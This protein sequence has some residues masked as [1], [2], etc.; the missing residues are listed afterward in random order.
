MDLATAA[1]LKI[2]DTPPDEGFVKVYA[3][4]PTGV[5]FTSAEV[6]ATATGSMLFKCKAWNF[7]LQECQGDWVKIADITPGEDYIFILTPDDPGLAESSGTFFEG[8]ESNSLVTNNWSTS[9]AGD[10]WII[11]PTATSPGAYGGS[12]YYGFVEVN[13]GESILTTNV[14][15]AGYGTIVFSFYAGTAALDIGEYLA[16]DWYNGTDWIQLM[17]VED[18][19]TYTFYSYSL[20]NVADD[21]A[22]LAIRFRCSSAQNSEECYLDNI[23]VTGTEL[24]AII[25]LEDSYGLNSSLGRVDS[26]NTTNLEEIEYMELNFSIIAYGGD[27]DSW[28][29]NYT[30]AGFSSCAPGNKQSSQCYN[31]TNADPYKWIQFI[32][33]TNTTTYDGTQG[34]QGDRII[35]TQTGS[36][37]NINISIRIDEHYNPNV[38]KWYAALYNFSDVKWQDGTS[39]RITKNNMLK[40]EVNQDLIPL[41]ADQYKLDFRVNYSSTAPSQPLQAYL[42]NSSYTTGNPEV[43]ASCAIVTEKL[44]GQLQDDGTKFRGIFTKQLIDD[45]GDIKYVI[46]RTDQNN[47]T[48]Y[49]SIK[50]Y[51]ATAPAYTTHWNYSEDS[52]ASWLNLADGYE[53]ELNINWFYNGVDPTAFVYNLWANTTTGGSN[54]LEGNIAWAIDSSQNYPPI[55]DLIVPQPNQT[56]TTPYNI[57]FTAVDPNDD[58]INVSLLLYQNGILNTTIVTDMNQSNAS[59]YWIGPQAKG[60]YNLTIKACELGTADLYCSNDTREIHIIDNST[61]SVFDVIPVAGSAFSSNVSIEIAV[62][63]TDDSGVDTVLANITYPNSTVLQLTLSNVAS[64]DKYNDYFTTPYLAGRYNVT[65]IANDTSN[66]VNS[67]VTTYFNVSVLDVTSPTSNSPADQDLE[68]GDPSS[69]TW[70]LQDDVAPGYYYIERDGVLYSGPSAWTIGTSIIINPLDPYPFLATLNYTIFFNDSSGN[71]GT[72]DT[73][74]ITVNDTEFPDCA[75]VE[76]AEGAPTLTTIT[77]DGNMSDWDGVLTND[78]N[79]VSDLSLAAGDLDTP[80]T[81]DRDLT[82]VGYTWDDDWMYFFW[83]RV[84]SGTNQVSMIVYIDYDDDGYMN[85]TDQVVKFVWTGSNALY[86]SDLYDYNPENPSGDIMR[87]SGYNMNGSI[88]VNK[89]LERKI[90]GGTSPGI[91]LEVRLNWSELGIS[92]PAPLNFHFSSGQGSATNLPSNLEDNAEGMEFGYGNLLFQPDRSASTTNGT[93]VYY[94]HDIKN[95]GMGNE[96]VNLYNYSTEGWNVTIYHPNGTLIPDT[97]ADTLPDITLDTGNFTTIIVKVDVP[98]N[99]TDGTMDYT[100][101]TAIPLL[102]GNRTVIDTTSVGAISITPDS[103]TVALTPGTTYDYNFAVINQQDFADTIEINVTSSQGWDV[104]LLYANGTPLTDTD[105]DSLIDVGL[106]QP[107]E[108]KDILLRIV[109]PPGASLGTVDT[110]TITINSSTDLSIYDTSTAVTTV[111]EEL[112]IASN[113]TGSAGISSSIFYLM[114]V[115]NSQDYYDVIDITHDSDMNWSISLYEMD[116]VTLLNDTDSDGIPDI[117][118]ISGSGT[119]QQFYVKVTISETASTGDSD[120]TLIYANSSVNSSV[121]DV[122]SLNTT[123]QNIVVY[124]NAARSIEESQFLK[125]ETVYTRGHS[126]CDYTNVYFVWIDSNSSTLRISNDIAVTGECEADDEWTSNSTSLIGEY[127]VILYNAA[128]DLEISRANFDIIETTPPVSDSP[129]DQTVAVGDLTSIVWTLNDNEIGGDFYIEKD[130]VLF[131]GPVAWDDGD[132]AIAI[133]DTQFTGTYNYTI[134]FD[135][136]SDND[137]APDTVLIT[138]V[139]NITLSCNDYFE[140]NVTPTLV[141]ITIDGDVSDWDAILYNGKNY[142]S[143][144]SLIE[145]DNDPVQTGDRDAKIY[146]YTWDDDYMYMYY[147][148]FVRGNRQVS[149]IAY[150]D[151]DLN[152]KMDATDKMIKFVWF[153]SNRNVDADLYN[154][155]PENPSGDSMLGTGYNMNGTISHNTTLDQDF[156][157]GAENGVELEGR[158]AWSDLGLSGP[159]PFMI[160][161]AVARGSGTNLPTQLEDNLGSVI[162]TGYDHLIF[163]PDSTKAG[164]PGDSVYHTHYLLNCGLEGDLI[165]FTNISLYGWNLTY[166][167]PN[168]TIISDSDSDSYPDI[169]LSSG[170]FSTIIAKVDIPANISWN[171]REETNITAFLSDTPEVNA[172]VTDITKALLIAI[173]P[174]WRYGFQ[175]PNTTVYLPYTVYSFMDDTEVI[176]IANISVLLGWDSYIL[177]ENYTLATDTNNNNLTDLGTF[178]TGQYKNIYLRVDIPANA[179]IGTYDIFN[180]TINASSDPT[181]YDRANA[182]VTASYRLTLEPNYNRTIVAGSSTFYYLTLTHNWNESDVF[183]LTYT[184]VENWTTAFYNT[185]FTLITDTDTDSII[186]TGVVSGI[187]GVFNFYVKVTAPL[188]MISGNYELTD[189]YAN[190][191]LDPTVYDTALLNTTASSLLI[192]E[193]ANR[194]VERY[195]YEIGETVY[196]RSFDLLGIPTVYFVWFDLNGTIVRTS[197]NISVVNNTADD[198]LV[199]NS[200]IEKGVYTTMVVNAQTDETIVTNTWLLDD[201][202]PDVFDLVPV[203]GTEYTTMQ[204]IEIAANVTDNL[205]IHTVYFNITYPNGSSYITY[206]NN[207]LGDKYNVSFYIPDILGQ[208]NITWFAN[209]TNNNINNSETTYFLAID[210]VPANVSLV[211]P[212]DGYSTTSP[213]VSLVCNAT[214]YYGVVNITLYTNING[215]WAPY[216]TDNSTG[217]YV[218]ATFNLTGL[219]EGTYQ[220]N[221]LVYDVGENPAWAETNWSFTKDNTPPFIN[222]TYPPPNSSIPN[223][224][225]NFTWNVTDNL[226]DNLTCN[227]TIDGVVNVSNIISLEGVLTGYVV[228]GFD[229]GGHYW[230]VTCWDGAGNTNTSVTNNFTVDVTLPNITLDGPPDGYDTTDPAINFTWNVTDNLDDNLTCNLTLNGVVS[231]SGIPALDGALSSYFLTAIPEDFYYWN[232][233][234][235]DDAGNTKTSVTWNFTMNSEPPNITLNYPPD[236]SSLPNTTVVFNWTTTDIDVIACNLTVNGVVNV[237]DISVLSGVPK[238]YPVGVFSEGVHFWNVTCWDT[239][240]HVNTSVTWNFTV[241]VTP[242]NLTLEG[243]IPGD[244]LPP[245]VTFT[246]NVTDNLDD[247][248]TCNLTVDGVVNASDIS[249]TSGA[250]TSYL[251]TGFADGIHYWNVTCWD[252]AGNTNTSVTWNFS[253]DATPPAIDLNY[254]P[255]G[256]ITSDRRIVFN[257]TATDTFDD[258]LTCNLTVGGNLAGS[259][260][261][262]AS[263]IPETYF[264]P[265]YPLVALYDGLYY[266][267]VTCWDDFYNTNNSVTWNFTVDTTPP[268]VVLEYPPDD[269]STNDT[270]VAFNC[271]ATDAT[272]VTSIKLYIWNGTS[273]YYGNTTLVEGTSASSE[274]IVALAPNNNYTWNCKVNDTINNSR[275]G[276]NRTLITDTAP[277]DLEYVSPTETSGTVLDRDYIL[278]NVTSNDTRLANITIYLYDSAGTLIDSATT[279]SSP[280]FE[281]FTG[282]DP[283]LYYFN[284]SGYDDAGNVAWLETRNVTIGTVIISLIDV[285]GLNSTF[286]RFDDFETSTLDDIEYMQLNFSINSTCDIDSWYL[287]FTADGFDGCSLGNKQNDICYDYHDDTYR[288]IQFINDTDS[289]N[290]DGTE[291]NQG[292][293]ILQTVTGTDNIFNLSYRI[294]EHY[295]PNLFQWYEALYNFSDSKYQDGLDQR[296]VTS[297]IIKV[298]LDPDIIPLDADQYKLDFYLNISDQVAKPTSP[299]EAYACNSSYTTGD[300]ESVPECQFIISKMADE[301]Q[302][303]TTRFRGVFS[304]NFVDGLDDWGYIILKSDE[305]TG[306]RYFH[307]LS[308][309][310][311]AENYTTH[312][313]YSTDDGDTWANLGDGYELDMNLNWF[314]GGADPTTFSYTLWV[315]TTNCDSYTLEGRVPWKIGHPE[316]DTQDFHCVV[317][318]TP[319]V[320]EPGEQVLLQTDVTFTDGRAVYE[321]N[322]SEV[323]VHTSKIENGSSVLVD[324]G[325]GIYFDNGIWFYEFDT[326]SMDDGNYMAFVRVMT[327]TVP[328]GYMHCTAV[329]TVSGRGIFDLHG[330][331]PDMVDV[332]TSVRLGVEVTKNGEKIPADLLQDA[333]LTVT[334]INGTNQTFTFNS[335]NTQDGLIYA[336]GFFDEPGVY[337]LNWSVNYY[338]R[339]KYFSEVIVV[340]EYEQSLANISNQISGPIRDLLVENRERLL[341]VLTELELAQDFTEEE[342]FLITDSVNSMSKVISHLDKEEITPEEAEEELSKLQQQ[343]VDRLGGKITGHLVYEGPSK[344]RITCKKLWFLCWWYWILILILGFMVVATVRYNLHTKVYHDVYRPV[345]RSVQRGYDSY[346]R[347][348]YEQRQM[349]RRYELLLMKLKRSFGSY[350]KRRIKQSYYPQQRS[351]DGNKRLREFFDMKGRAFRKKEKQKDLHTWVPFSKASAVREKTLDRYGKDRE[352]FSKPQKMRYESMIDSLVDRWKNHEARRYEQRAKSER[353]YYRRNR[354]VKKV[355]AADVFHKRPEKPEPTRF[356]IMMDSWKKKRKE[357]ESR[358]RREQYEREEEI[359][360]MRQS[361]RKAKPSEIFNKP[362]K[363]EPKQVPRRYEMILNKVSATTKD[364]KK[365]REQQKQERLH[366]KEEEQRRKAILAVAKQRDKTM[367]KERTAM[368]QMQTEGK[369]GEVENV[370]EDT[371]EFEP[372]NE[373]EMTTSISKD[374]EA[375]EKHGFAIKQPKAEREKTLFEKIRPKGQL[376]YADFHYEKVEEKTDSEEE[377]DDQQSMSYDKLKEKLIPAGVDTRKMVRD[378][379]N[380]IPQ[381]EAQVKHHEV[382]SRMLSEMKDVHEAEPVIEQQREKSERRLKQFQKVLALKRE[383]AGDIV[384]AKKKLVPER[385]TKDISPYKNMSLSKKGRQTHK[386]RMLSELSDVHSGKKVKKP[387]KETAKEAKKEIK[388]AKKEKTVKTPSAKLPPRRY[389]IILNKLKNTYKKKKNKNDKVLKKLKEVQKR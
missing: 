107:E 335:L 103:R 41:D 23:N 347:N 93:S 312:W 337:F 328:T 291:E 21:N 239:V 202:P 43:T 26:F 296:I 311:T 127:H 329:F 383:K 18:I 185:D 373:K 191:S 36:G 381:K 54:Y 226:A 42:C 342:I 223:T 222:I 144:L 109:I 193:N 180:I 17:S 277:P 346:S 116:K 211:S 287:N 271:S 320:A 105:S 322:I 259:Y 243:P 168:E 134:F 81:A 343:L 97:D 55:S 266:W 301:L 233:T 192:Y 52:G 112:T 265:E 369:A 11:A 9:G 256:T 186:D 288:W 126:L 5:N 90:Y 147:R 249:A 115:T 214:D 269:H 44:P 227:L 162:N 253:V 13:G 356:E 220:W 182:N 7:T 267:N 106:F 176:D 333:N 367:E 308:Y 53:T 135:D 101:I 149:M 96:V 276:N 310:A 231:A 175:P 260:I 252:D 268:T 255:D 98:S 161:A 352:I 173:L 210:A 370:T 313:E 114:T 28:Y 113:Q 76:G 8:F 309:A 189:V 121:Y 60:T 37:N 330:I 152:G 307:L 159:A 230:N 319:H 65:F 100:N 14:S 131:K 166:Y 317:T 88:S 336:D 380:R 22:D 50:T 203:E 254:P 188:N 2:D 326:S 359:N 325:R 245:E 24:D 363:E 171:T 179:T 377:F 355:K 117:G 282:L 27:V 68:L 34:N 3:I 77:I 246:W 32:N 371:F 206:P 129:S 298:E 238:T 45:L 181:Y 384:R 25:T 140:I 71:N 365:R 130:G 218:E 164:R 207:T 306:G 221:C 341:E 389:E 174:G 385:E 387:K 167:Y 361:Y 200:S 20:P 128:N 61:P 263:G 280:N 376:K 237:S 234:C 374:H 290:Y 89:I 123:A 345:K 388:I 209:D 150:L 66:N 378:I 190:S 212:Y 172:S 156:I 229:E 258:N 91:N 10:P 160:Q 46:L 195:I 124:E 351:Y 165:D 302:D 366:E 178:Y 257:W 35:L 247:N 338:N 143:D 84:D 205:E 12:S 110:S 64:T 38:F 321:D 145:G 382:R 294:D 318:E 357:T 29:L 125:T 295:N 56:I 62:N 15:T 169:N 204:T 40:I 132:V 102:S 99:T 360:R 285:Y 350:Q 293:R 281:N 208:F 47:P 242:P 303:G 79:F 240:D 63:V 199:T 48:R 264:Y 386:Q 297:N 49:Y 225:I 251:V 323:M 228:S 80:G 300:P 292:D 216:A 375:L 270:D 304:R 4:D 78:V 274:W 215:S 339:T 261:D 362:R 232:V 57:T 58:N 279:T 118:N 163:F 141:N 85:S 364:L 187:G 349:P 372:E 332:N 379:I 273:L 198:E 278:V 197:N 30:A 201:Q 83:G 241:D 19:T 104:T 305:T 219:G 340:T 94:A 331:T 154:Y 344:L 213:N 72:P 283:G 138:V 324:D 111:S 334:L 244:R 183:D 119:T 184:F 262:A 248:L 59:Y 70:V 86:N 151:Y 348:A 314:Y 170:N 108:E 284:V 299:L 148:R 354:P 67:S 272:G 289:V 139:D 51:A 275:W 194:T 217:N 6:T 158:V 327:N 92:D 74:L 31:Y 368:Q 153:G 120:F 82:Q 1:D 224:T 73:V 196:A 33:G 157:G 95:C 75:D 142:V 316:T 137:G 286:S 39:Q 177:Y 315:N 358:K 122:A 133:P 250:N 155:D 236:G 16:A 87:G 136:F 146:A 69:I 235:W 353:D